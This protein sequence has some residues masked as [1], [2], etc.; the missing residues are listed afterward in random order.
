MIPIVICPTLLRIHI[1]LLFMIRRYTVDHAFIAF[2]LAIRTNHSSVSYHPTCHC[3]YHTLSSLNVCILLY[4]ILEAFTG[5]SSQPLGP[6]CGITIDFPSLFCTGF[7][8][9]H[10]DLPKLD[11][12]A[13]LIAVTPVNPFSELVKLVP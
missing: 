12:Q 2:V 3:I 7:E 6:K 4:C 10:R 13:V 1:L 8:K 11:N 9:L 5:G